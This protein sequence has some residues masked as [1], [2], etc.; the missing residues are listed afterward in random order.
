[1]LQNASL[2]MITLTEAET[3]S[4]ILSGSK[5]FGY[6]LVRF[7][8]MMRGNSMKTLTRFLSLVLLST[9]A[10]CSTSFDSDTYSDSSAGRAQAVR[11]GTIVE[12][13]A[14]KIQ[15]ETQK[16]AGTLA[17]AAIG[18]ILG[19]TIGG[20]ST[21]NALGGV[22]GAVAGGVAGNAAG[23]AIGTQDGMRYIIK[24]DD[25]SAISI[26][27]APQ[28]NLPIGTRVMILTGSNGH[29]RILP[30]TTK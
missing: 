18:A 21:A 22:G 6:N 4:G 9:L 12:A 25:G 8:I 28:P 2:L 17:G 13:T 3:N 10:A 16:G 23:K 30:D 7:K 27:Q 29:D 24:L 1:M 11:Y 14:V 26:V 19:S 20:G 5:F 15:G